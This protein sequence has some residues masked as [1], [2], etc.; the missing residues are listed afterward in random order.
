MSVHSCPFSTTLHPGCVATMTSHF[1]PTTVELMWPCSPHFTLS[2]YTK[3]T[4]S[5]TVTEGAQ[6]LPHTL[7]SSHHSFSS[8]VSTQQLCPRPTSLCLCFL[9]FLKPRLVT[10]V[11]WIHSC[12]GILTRGFQRLHVGGHPQ[13][14]PNISCG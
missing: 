4:A 5:L 9:C 10:S 12:C 3:A 11:L 7:L 8:C 13:S 2:H 6:V 14:L 1:K